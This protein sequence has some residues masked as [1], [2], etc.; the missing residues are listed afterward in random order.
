MCVCVCIYILPLEYIFLED[1][2]CIC[3]HIILIHSE[4][5]KIC[6]TTL[7]LN[8]HFALLFEL[9]NISIKFGA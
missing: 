3:F 6:I 9:A 1:N 2:E 4:H 5:S 8:D 7:V